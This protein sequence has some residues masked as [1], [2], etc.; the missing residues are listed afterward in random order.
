MGGRSRGQGEG[1]KKRGQGEGNKKRRRGE[2]GRERRHGDLHGDIAAV[3]KLRKVIREQIEIDEGFATTEKML[4]V[5]K[6]LDENAEDR[7]T[8]EELIRIFGEEH[9]KKLGGLAVARLNG[10][11][12]ERVL[13]M[14]RNGD[15]EGG[16]VKDIKT[17]GFEVALEEF[18]TNENEKDV[19]GCVKCNR[20]KKKE[21]VRTA[22]TTK[23]DEN[24]EATNDDHPL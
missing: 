13:T 2:G 12:R 7:L 15:G 5:E 4:E 22:D 9:V 20:C 18:N 8:A 11:N 1:N 24:V 23:N 14:L 19:H 10:E 17:G 6:A 16:Y 21:V 3:E